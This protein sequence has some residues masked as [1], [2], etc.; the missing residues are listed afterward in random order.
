MRTLYK[1][2]EL[3]DKQGISFEVIDLQT[4]YP[5]DG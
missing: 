3:A 1:V 4:I 2:R 5:Y